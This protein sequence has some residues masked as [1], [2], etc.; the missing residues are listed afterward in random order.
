MEFI[1]AG[2]TVLELL[3]VGVL[4]YAL[5]Q[6]HRAE[7]ERREWERQNRTLTHGE[8]LNALTR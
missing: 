8:D 6:D 2:A 1:L 3:V 4:V 7:I 5:W